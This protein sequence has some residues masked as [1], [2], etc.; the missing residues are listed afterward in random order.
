MVNGFQA[1]DGPLS[2]REFMDQAG[3]DSARGA[4]EVM[5]T[6]KKMTYQAINDIFKFRLIY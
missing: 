2:L 3:G 5:H 6:R 1:R 4:I